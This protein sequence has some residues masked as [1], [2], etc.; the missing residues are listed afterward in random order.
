MDVLHVHGA[1]PSSCAPDRLALAPPNCVPD[2][3]TVYAGIADAAAAVLR[4]V[5]GMVAVVVWLNVGVGTSE[6]QH[7]ALPWV[8]EG[9]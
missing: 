9:V 6:L 1:G 7:Q 3:L 8:K 5:L 2:G 4:L